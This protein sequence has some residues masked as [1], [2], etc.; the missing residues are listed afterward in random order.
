[1]KIRVLGTG[2][3]GMVGSRVVQLLGEEFEFFNFSLEEGRDI[4]DREALARVFLTFRPSFC[5]HF[6][7]KTDVDACEKEKNLGE[8]SESFKINVLGTKKLL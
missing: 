3:S 2:L 7:A 8:E 4:L 5:L 6:A 1:M